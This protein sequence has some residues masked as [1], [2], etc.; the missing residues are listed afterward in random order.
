MAGRKPS[1]R[2]ATTSSTARGY[3]YRWQKERARYLEQNP[4]CVRCERRGRVV[5]ATVVNHRV[6]HRG[7]QTLFWD[8]RNWEAVCKPCHDGV[9]QAEEKSGIVKGTDIKGRPTDPA[10]PWNRSVE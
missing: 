2:G 5:A 8:E 7:D 10:H 1:W 9:I 4:C 3:G 6:P